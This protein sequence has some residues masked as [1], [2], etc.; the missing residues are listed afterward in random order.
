MFDLESYK[1]GFLT[2]YTSQRTDLQL[3]EAFTELET[4][5]R[6]HGITAF[7]LTQ[8]GLEDIFQKIVQTV[9]EGKWSSQSDELE[10]VSEIDDDDLK[11]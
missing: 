8:Y 3:S 11:I 5:S 6:S 10:D 9:N 7:S 2:S 4:N 1:S